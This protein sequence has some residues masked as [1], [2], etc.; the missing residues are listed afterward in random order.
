M[1]N[2]VIIQNN[3]ARAIYAYDSYDAA[4]AAFHIEMAYRAEG[5]DSTVCVILNRMGELIKREDWHREVTPVEQDIS[6]IE[7]EE[8]PVAEE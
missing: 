1:F 8:T 3:S 4:L 5:R 2:L 7:P 6:V